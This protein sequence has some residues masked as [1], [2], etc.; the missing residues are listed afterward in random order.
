MSTIKSERLGKIDFL[1][2]WNTMREEA[3]KELTDLPLLDEGILVGGLDLAERI[4]RSC[5]FNLQW[6]GQFLDQAGVR[7]WAHTKYPKIADDV[8]IIYK[9]L[10]ARGFNYHKI[11]YDETGNTAVGY[12]FSQELEGVMDPIHFTN[13]MKLDA[14]RV[15]N[16]LKDLGMLRLEPDDPVIRQMDEQQ[17]VVAA[18]G[19]QRYEHPSGSHDDRFWGL[20]IACWE[21]VELIVGLPPVG[22][23]TYHAAEDMG[24]DP[25]VIIDSIMQYSKFKYW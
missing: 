3:D 21:A 4:D 18:S 1:L 22:I 6:N 9:T 12:L 17:K 8:R 5:L 15:V 19:N 11:G 7:E 13:P 16:Y 20:A 25:D 14:V 2:K 23:A 10:S 24:E